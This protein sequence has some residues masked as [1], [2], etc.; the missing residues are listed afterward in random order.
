MTSVFCFIVFNDELRIVLLGK[1]GDGKSSSGNTILKEE[2]FGVSNGPNAKTTSCV[3]KEKTIYGRTIKLIDTPGFYDSDRPETEL[4]KELVKCIVQCSPGVHAFLLV[5]RAERYSEQEKELIKKI[6]DTF[7]EDVLKHTVIL[8]TRGDQLNKNQTIKQFVEESE[9]L[10]DLAQKCGGRYHV[11]DNKHWKSRNTVEVRELLSTIDKMVCDNGGHFYT[12][13][14][15]QEVQGR[16]QHEEDRIK[17]GNKNMS[18]RDVK[19]EAT[20]RV[21]SKLLVKLAGVASGVLFGALIGVGVAAVVAVMAVVI[22]GKTAGLKPTQTVLGQ[23]AT[24]AMGSAAAG[25][26]TAGVGAWAAGSVAVTSGVIGGIVGGAVGAE[27]AE[28]AETA[29][30]A[31]VNAFRANID[32]AK[33]IVDSVK[34]FGNEIREIANAPENQLNKSYMKLE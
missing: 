24:G 31:A 32:L 4:K 1:T 18:E 11:I 12:N 6:T 28:N 10:K 8:F 15:L 27:A 2:V 16:V 23:A 20:N 19:E 22:V 13:E 14:L 9:Q 33:D 26:C 25:A 29:G 34:T 5:L 21:A 30:E 3:S 17:K 7:G